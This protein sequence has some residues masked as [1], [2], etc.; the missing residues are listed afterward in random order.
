MFRTSSLPGL[1]F[2][3]LVLLLSLP[4]PLIAQ[5]TPDFRGSFELTG[6][7]VQALLEA[8]ENEQ[9]LLSERSNRLTQNPIGITVPYPDGEAHITLL[10][11]ISQIFSLS[12]PLRSRSSGNS[13]ATFR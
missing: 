10:P 1:S 4:A 9:V 12:H 13:I 5:E 7:E 8:G 11:N 2:L 6:N 3:V